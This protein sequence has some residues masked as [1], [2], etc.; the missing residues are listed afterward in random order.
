MFRQFLPYLEYLII[1]IF[2]NFRFNVDKR[3]FLVGYGVYG[4][5]FGP[6]EYD[7]VIELIHTA[8]G[9][10]IAKNATSFSSDGSNYTY[11][12]IFKEPVEILPNTCYTASTTFEVY[13]LF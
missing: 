8:S 13:Y 9:K 2:T 5:V 1:A 12:L 11:R 4:S 7:V 10:V 6:A 3:I